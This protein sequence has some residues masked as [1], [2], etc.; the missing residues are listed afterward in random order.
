MYLKFPL[1]TLN[2]IREGHSPYKLELKIHAKVI[3]LRNSSGG[4]CNGTR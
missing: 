3:L 4:L 2:S 1:E